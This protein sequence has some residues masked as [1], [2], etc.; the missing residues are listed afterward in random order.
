MTLLKILFLILIIIPFALFLLFI[1]D[2]LM[3][4]MPSKEEIE[5]EMSPVERRRSRA[6]ARKRG[7]RKGRRTKRQ[8]SR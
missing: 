2:R 1:I 4:Q 3:D 7:K 8:G 6:A 5:A